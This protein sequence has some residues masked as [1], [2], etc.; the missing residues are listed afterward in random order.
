LYPREVYM[1]RLLVVEDDVHQAELC[2]QELEEEGFEVVVAHDGHEA[3]KKLEEHEID[4]VV[5]D[6]SMPGMDGIEAL[7]KILGRDNTMPVI[8]H[9]AYAHYK[10][11]FM[12]WTAE[13]YVIKS[14]DLSEL[15]TKIREVLDQHKK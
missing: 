5:L 3:L 6:I 14:S 10:D 2:R 1:E 8:I 12:T 13:H 11:N 7:G 15:K 4:L 9:T